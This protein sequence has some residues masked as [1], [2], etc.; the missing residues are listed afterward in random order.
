MEV[1]TGGTSASEAWPAVPG[2]WAKEWASRYANITWPR[3]HPTSW[4]FRK[5]G[6]KPEGLCC[7]GE[8]SLVQSSLLEPEPVFI[9]PSGVMTE[10][11]SHLEVPVSWKR[12]GRGQQGVL[13]LVTLEAGR[14]VQSWGSSEVTQLR[15]D[16]LVWFSVLWIPDFR[17]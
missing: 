16:S 1:L 15:S 8:G 17:G 12:G 6:A 3:H 13:E 5:T 2:C 11:G 9:D 4:P 14:T 10:G 7:P